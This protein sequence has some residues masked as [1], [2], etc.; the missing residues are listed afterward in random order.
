VN[1]PATG[2]IPYQYHT[3]S[4]NFTQDKW[5]EAS[6]IRPGNRSVV[7]HVIP[8]IQNPSMKDDVNPGAAGREKLSGYPPG[9]QPKS[10]PP[11]CSQAH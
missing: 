10:Y 2:V 11:G 1:V 9:E 6:E 8:Y 4:T 7:H 5:I 3:I